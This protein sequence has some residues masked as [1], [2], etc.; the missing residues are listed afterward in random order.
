MA[1]KKKIVFVVNTV[2]MTGGIRV[3]FEY[4]KR[5]KNDGHEVKIVHLLKLRPGLKSSLTAVFKKIKWALRGRNNIGWFDLGGVSI[6]HQI[7]LGA[8]AD[9]LIATAYETAKP[10][11]DHK[12]NVKKIYFIQGY[13]SWGRKEA[14]E[15]YQLPIRKITISIWLKDLLKEKFG[16]DAEVATP[17]IDLEQFDVKKKQFNREKV[18]AMMYHTLPEKGAKIGLGALEKV[19]VAHPEVKFQIF[20]MYDP[21]QLPKN[22]TYF[23]DP[24]RNKL[25][26][27]YTTSDIYIIPS[28]SEGFGLT[29]LEAMSAG[30]ALVVTKTGGYA[31]FSTDGESAIWVPPGN[32][33]AIAEAT[34]E[35]IENEE[36]L[37]NIAESGRKAIQNFSLEKAY[38]NFRDLILS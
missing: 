16:A 19:S 2:G 24:S 17:G 37:K 3:V 23:K 6:S 36:K 18:I 29:A 7:S 11:S 21:P 31:D 30:C 26:E 15:T 38:R 33:D 9:I 28:L 4:A 20:G 13:E 5:L 12:A 22:A 27:I 8:N 14:N 25:R 35:L 34:I 32:T 1:D 10:V